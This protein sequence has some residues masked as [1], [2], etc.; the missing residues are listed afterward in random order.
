VR[1]QQ[2]DL[3]DLEIWQPGMSLS[4]NEPDISG[5]PRLDASLGLSVVLRSLQHYPSLSGF[6]QAED[7]QVQRHKGTCQIALIDGEVSSCV[8][9]DKHNTAHS[10]PLEH[11][12]ANEKKR[13]TSYLWSF[14]PFQRYASRTQT[15]AVLV[16][17]EK[18]IFSHNDI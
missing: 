15:D 11:I 1:D 3:L 13:K 18:Q 16:G 10:I 8:I 2:L 14:Q 9:V 7:V 6:I 12:T 17:L 5:S 4:L